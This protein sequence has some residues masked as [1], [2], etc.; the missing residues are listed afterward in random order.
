MIAAWNQTQ[1]LPTTPQTQLDAFAGALE[2]TVVTVVEDH[3]AH[4]YMDQLAQMLGRVHQLR[5]EVRDEHNDVGRARREPRFDLS[6]IQLGME[7]LASRS[8]GLQLNAQAHH[9]HD[10]AMTFEGLSHRLKSA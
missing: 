6:V 9:D 4:R 7:E 8:V 2:D 5:D 3:R 10:L 1:V